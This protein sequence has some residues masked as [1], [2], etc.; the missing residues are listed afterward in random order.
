MK[1]DVASFLCRSRK[2]K[3]FLSLFVLFKKHS[4]LFVCTFTV[5]FS[6]QPYSVLLQLAMGS[7]TSHLPVAPLSLLPPCTP[8]LL[9]HG[10]GPSYDLLLSCVYG[11]IDL[12]V[13]MLCKKKINIS[14]D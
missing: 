8:S 11:N 3:P 12:T 10:T 5:L 13:C 4:S 14:V 9:G 7:G 6:H 1:L 2:G